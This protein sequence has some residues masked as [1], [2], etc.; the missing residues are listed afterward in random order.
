MVGEVA[1]RRHIPSA[2]TLSQGER[3]LKIGSAGRRSHFIYAFAPA[4]PLPESPSAAWPGRTCASR[5]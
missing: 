1:G 3:D 2:P 5:C 4:A